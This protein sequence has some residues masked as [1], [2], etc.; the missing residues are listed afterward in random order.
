METDISRDTAISLYEKGIVS[1]QTVLEAFDLDVDQEIKRKQEDAAFNIPANAR[2]CNNLNRQNARI[3]NARRN[4]E[5]LL[6]A[7][8]PN[9]YTTDDADLKKLKS[10]MI[11]E[12]YNNLA[13]MAEVKD[14]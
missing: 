10:K 12:V 13:I 7:I 11:T 8:L 4:V 6:K 14:L 1:A 3:E 2:V 5:A 9:S